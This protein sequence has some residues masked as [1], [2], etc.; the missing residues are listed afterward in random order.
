M[1]TFMY[2]NIEIL[3]RFSNEKNSNAMSSGKYLGYVIHDCYR[4]V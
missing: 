3:N 1:H 2:W 4:K